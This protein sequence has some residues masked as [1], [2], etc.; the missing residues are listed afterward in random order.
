V[1]PAWLARIRVVAV[2]DRR[3]LDASGAA[4]DAAF[5]AAIERLLA[6][7]DRDTLLVQI[8][9]KDLDGGP[10]LA[11]ARVA[12]AAG[13]RV[14]INDRVDV[15][16]AAGADGVHLPERGLA[17][18][19]ARALLGGDDDRVLGVSCH[20]LAGVRGA[21]AAGV[22]LVQLGPIWETP[23]KG[24]AIGTDALAAA[25][26][27][28]RDAGAATRLV[29]IGGIDSPE[30]IAAAARAGA[31]AVAAIRAIWT[32]DTIDANSVRDAFAG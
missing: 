20:D 32:R 1:P 17:I 29:A 28:I 21:I 8:R 9:E 7:F 26:A 12:I 6:R 24:P 5:G 23:G 14:A 22:D 4:R 10:L 31:D 2:T 13:A 11:L 18:A 27:A 15:A 30:R 19:D 3:L 25:R 16:V